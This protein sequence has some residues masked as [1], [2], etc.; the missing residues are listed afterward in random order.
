MSR[1]E[2]K[3]MLEIS[4]AQSTLWHSLVNV[5]LASKTIDHADL[6][7]KIS[8]LSQ[9]VPESQRGGSFKHITC[10]A[11]RFLTEVEYPDIEKAPEWI[12]KMIRG[13]LVAIKGEAHPGAD[14]IVRDGKVI[15][16]PE[17]KE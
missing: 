6:A 11:M 1:N 9:Q 4:A 2:Q 14:W 5:L 10:G 12:K 3:V 13:E 17:G 16:Q 15:K 8:E 7:V